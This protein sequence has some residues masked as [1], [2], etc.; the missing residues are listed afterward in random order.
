MNCRRWSLIVVCLGLLS[1]CAF[2]DAHL[3]IGYDKNK[4]IAGPLSSVPSLAVKMGE[5]KD[6]RPESDVVGYKRNGFGQHTADIKP[7]KPVPDIVS[8]ALESMFRKSNHQVLE[9]S[10]IVVSGDIK[11]FWFDVKTGF[12]TVEFMGDVAMHLVVK[13]SKTSVLIY[14]QNYTGN[15]SEKSMGGFE[16]TWQ[17]VLNEALANMIE[18][19]SLDTGLADALKNRTE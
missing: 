4:A 12:W 19:I 2:S 8:D 11:T 9:D 7:Q 1:G 17:K 10:D 15:F 13:N 16:K 6:S 3:D 14:E 5:F 18:N